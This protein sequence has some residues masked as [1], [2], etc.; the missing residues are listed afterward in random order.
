MKFP[1][2]ALLLGLLL[3]S[4]GSGLL[5]QTLS[6][7]DPFGSAARLDAPGPSPSDAGQTPPLGKGAPA[8]AA[9]ATPAPPTIIDSQNM[10]YDEK[11]RIAIFT[12]EDYGVY[13]KDPSFI[14]YCDKLTAHM[15]KAAGPAVPG[16]PGAKGKPTPTPASIL[17]PKPGAS[18][19]ATPARGGGLQS[20]VAEG[21]PDRPVVIVQDKPPANPG[22]QPVHNVGIAAKA[23]YNADTG[24]VIL[25]GWPRVSQGMDTQIATSRDTVMIMN[26][27]GHTMVAH[28]PTRTVIQQQDQP[29]K[30]G[31]NSSDSSASP[32]P[33]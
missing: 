6:G 26:K 21:V 1:F 22:D 23:D 16:A 30:T 14:V 13:V 32:T 17:K 29:K 15:R 28:G 2:L 8:A 20:A 4:P 5:A 10:D 19:D 11:T 18:P 31:T 12:G 3:L 24:D 25:T 33:Q 7:G 27:D 9:S